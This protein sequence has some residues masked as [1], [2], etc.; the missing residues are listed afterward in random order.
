MQRHGWTGA[1]E[2]TRQNAAEN[3]RDGAAN[4]KIEGVATAES[5]EELDQKAKDGAHKLNAAHPNGYNLRAGNGPN[6]M[7]SELRARIS[8][9]T[10][11]KHQ[12]TDETRRRLSESHVG[13]RLSDAA[14]VKLSAFH[15]GR[16]LSPQAQAASVKACQK[17]FVLFDPAGEEVRIVNMKKFCME[18]RLSPQKMC[19][20]VNGKKPHHKGWTGRHA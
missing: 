12:V 18:N 8:A 6:A 3:Q 14:K 17:A 20:V 10:I 16:P 15:K 13:K 1:E 4:F 11:G 5:Q 9:S 2:T 7:S 19:E